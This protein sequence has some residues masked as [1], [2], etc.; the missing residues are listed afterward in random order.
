MGNLISHSI[1]CLLTCIILIFNAFISLHA[2]NASTQ[3]T[4]FWFSFMNNN[5]GTP[6]QTCLILSA[7]RACSAT[8]SNPNTGWTTTVNIPAGGRVDVDVPLAQGYHSSSTDGVVY[9]L[10]CH[11]TSTDIISA[12]SMNYKDASFDGGH[13][14]PTSTLADEYMIETIP[15]GLNGSTVMLVGV[16]NGTGVNITPSAATTNGWPANST[17]HIT[18]NA[19]QVYQF[20]TT[21]TDGTFSG[22]RIITDDCKPLAVFAGGKCAQAP[23]GCTYCDHIYEPMVPVIYWGNH[24]IPTSSQTRTK[25]VVRVTALNANTTVRKNGTVVATLAAGGTYHFELT[26]GEGSCYIET[27]GPAVCY[28]YVTGQSCGGGN[29]D[30]SMVYITPIEQN[31]QKITFGTYENLGNTTAHYVNIVTPTI[32]VGSVTLDGNNISGQFSTVPGNAQY[33]FARVSISH[34]THTLQCDSGLVAHVYGLY[35]VT[36]Y[37]YSVGSNAIDLSN[38]MF[39]NEVNTADIP[40]D[41]MYCANRDID[42]E[43]QLNYQYNQITWYFGD[44]EDGVGNPLSHQYA[45]EGSYNV[46]AVIERGGLSNCFGT[47]YDTL[48]TVVNIPPLD[49]IPVYVS[50][51]G[52]GSYDFYGRE[53]TEPGV[54]L[55]TLETGSEC[56]SI[57]E[58]HLSFVPAEPIPVYKSIC[59]GESY[60]YQG[61]SYSQPGTYTVM[62][63]TVGGCDSIVELHLSFANLPTVSLGQD[64]VLCSRDEFPISLSPNNLN[65][66]NTYMWSTGQTG[67]TIDVNQE[68]IYSVTVISPE[69]C[70]STD[71]MEIRLQS[72]LSLEIIQS[73]D[74]CDR[75]VTT[76]TAT[77]NAPN[78]HWN[79]GETTPEIEVTSYGRYSVRV[80]DGPCEMSSSIDIERCPFNLYFPNCI[81]ASFEDGMNDE[82]RMWDPAEVKEF[83]IFIYD[84]WGMLVYHSTDPNFSWNG[85]VNGRVEANQIFSWRAFAVPKVENKKYA[86]NGSIL[87]L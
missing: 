35:N 49:P 61:E 45:T 24:F 74:F 30:P 86:F 1:R 82:F 46:M 4:D 70:V 71:E 28:L 22:T 66:A 41:Q 69:G 51:C 9:N 5:G 21:S 47:N 68:G 83:E 3:G 63:P 14:L 54:Y 85:K 15:P 7:E 16:E 50:I 72:E 10:G 57:I 76:L 11:V 38:S 53:L 34:A 64:K 60:W 37:A 77:T 62:I 73:E 55:D 19:G 78:I 6:T 44:G 75:G 12:Y 20:T 33:S 81:S 56:D 87:V 32:N 58:L 25:D 18:L 59:P 43:V 36:S 31:I 52:G 84:R 23:S 42:F 48:Y 80:H 27:S 2:Q 67:T 79:T 17:Q 8:V 13:L 29:G 40:E 26:S 65:P 39:V